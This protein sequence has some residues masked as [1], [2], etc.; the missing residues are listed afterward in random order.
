MRYEERVTNV[1]FPCII[2]WFKVFRRE[3]IG[4]LSVMI[5]VPD[6]RAHVVSILDCGVSIAHG[7]LDSYLCIC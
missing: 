5:S 3:F 6:I 1:S 2:P 7:D 4:I